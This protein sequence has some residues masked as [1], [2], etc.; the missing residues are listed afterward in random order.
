MPDTVRTVA[1]LQALLADGQ[2][3]GTITPQI[4]RDM[5]V[6]VSLGVI[7][8]NE[9]AIVAALAAGKVAV[10]LPGSYPIT[11]AL[12]PISRSGLIAPWGGA[13]I[14]RTG[15]FHAVDLAFAAACDGVV[16]EGFE[17]DGQSAI[18]NQSGFNAV[19]CSGRFAITNLAIRK[20]YI[21][22]TGGAGILLLSTAG[23]GSQGIVIEH[24][25]VKNTGTH[26]ILCQGYIDRTQI[27]D[28]TVENFSQ[29]YVDRPGIT[30]GRNA[31]YHIVRGT[32][33]AAG[34]R[35]RH[36]SRSKYGAKSP[37]KS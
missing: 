1:A 16:L 37:G 7:V 27:L 21:H 4:I 26:G 9:A 17:I 31:K 20:L 33:D 3:P 6:S 35:D 13:R 29:L 23:L 19:N 28:N 8:D 12:K 14:I 30:T 10:L 24:N 11:S 25:R 36:Q 18:Y 22:D 5:L 15:N 34:V 32:L 2:A